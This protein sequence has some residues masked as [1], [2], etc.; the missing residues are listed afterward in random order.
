MY[1]SDPLRSKRRSAYPLD[2]KLQ[3][4]EEAKASGS[5]NVT[6]KKHGISGTLIRKW[7]KDESKLRSALS[8]GRMFRLEYCKKSE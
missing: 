8:E 1:I 5:S 4:V 6:A 3:L 2:F 7:W